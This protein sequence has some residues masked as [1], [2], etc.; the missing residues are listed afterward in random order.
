M[1]WKAS[2]LVPALICASV[3]LTICALE[4]REESHPDSTH[5]Q[6]LEWMTYD[7]RMKMAARQSSSQVVTNL[8]LVIMED[9]SIEALLDGSLPYRFGLLWPRQVYARLLAELH[10]QGAKAVGFDVLFSELRPDHPPVVQD[11][12]MLGSDEFFAQEIK[13]SGNVILAQR[14]SMPADL[15]RTNAWAVGDLSIKSQAQGI[16]RRAPAFSEVVI[17][18]PTVRKAAHLFGWKLEGAI[19]ARDEILFPREDAG[20]NTLSLNAAGD[21]DVSLLEDQFDEPPAGNRVRPRWERP[22]IEERVWELGI[23]LAAYELKLDLHRAQVDLPGRKIEIPG[24]DGVRRVI[25]VDQLGR[26]FIDW[27]ITPTDPRLTKERIESLLE[28]YEARQAGRMAALT[29]RWAGKLVVVGSAATGGNLTDIGA[30]PLGN[31]TF[32]MSAYWNA[33]N[34][35]L[36]NRFIRPLPLWGRLALI[37]LLGAG[38]GII[39]MRTRPL[40]AVLLVGLLAGLYIAA[41]CGAFLQWRLWLPIVLPVLGSLLVTHVC[42]MIYLVRLEQRERRRTREIFGKIVSPQVARELLASEKLSVSGER[43]HMTVLF[44]DVRD[45]TTMTD[46]NQQRA[47]E[48]V[49][50]EKLGAAAAEEVF[51]AQAAEILQTI[52]LYLSIAADCI[53]K[54]DGTLDKYIGDCVMAFWGA[55]VANPR[56]AVACVQAVIDMQRAIF[57]LNQ[58]RRA[59]NERRGEENLRRTAQGEPLLPLLEI[60]SLGSGINSGLVTVGLMGSAAHVVNYTVFGREV[61]LAARLEG[62]SGRARILIGEHTFLELRR[63]D[64]ALAATCIAQPPLALKGFRDPIKAYEVPWHTPEMS[65]LEAGQSATIV[66]TKDKSHESPY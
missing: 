53:K 6:G 41:A 59:D 22:R 18:H 19:I 65:S 37:V 4:W 35:V 28:Q 21:F 8:G 54:H 34:S 9:T 38:A 33:A 62:A 26:F 10:A 30:T 44:A 2:W 12:T 7:W 40:R 29:N 32:L 45:F 15:F 23:V 50:R 11:G 47:E 5:L 61:N 57:E 14:T 36:M 66:R 1:K 31:E 63:D 39:T 13:K 17:W 3:T 60:L 51:N 55:P 64:P 20:T 24:A 16:L 52:N 58:Q 42:L 27:S 43:R 48:R 25:P 49:A 46:L 56:H